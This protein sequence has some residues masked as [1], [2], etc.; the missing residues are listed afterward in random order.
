MSSRRSGTTTPPARALRRPHRTS[1]TGLRRVPIAPPRLVAGTPPARHRT[2]AAPAVV[3]AGIRRAPGRHRV[4]PSRLVRRAMLLGGTPRSPAVFPR[5][6]LAVSPRLSLAVS[7]RLSLAVSPRPS[8]AGLPSAH[9]DALP[10]EACLL[11]ADSVPRQAVPPGAAVVGVAPSRTS[12][13]CRAGLAGSSRTTPSRRRRPRRRC[14]PRPPST[15]GR[16]RGGWRLPSRRRAP[17]ADLDHARPR[18]RPAEPSSRPPVVLSSRRRAG[19]PARRRPLR[20]R[21]S[22]PLGLVGAWSLGRSGLTRTR[23]R[24]LR[25]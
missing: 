24:G 15:P 12:S 2:M 23:G 19:A 8:L 17:G 7:P 13:R 14:R 21:R 16:R 9:R 5:L 22:R 1:R 11:R 10:R 3:R 25:R 6:S 4:L 20:S 18:H